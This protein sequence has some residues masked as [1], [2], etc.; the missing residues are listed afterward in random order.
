MFKRVLKKQII[1]ST[2]FNS[3]NS[4]KKLQLILIKGGKKMLTSESLI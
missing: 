3:F 2:Y 1:N 4:A